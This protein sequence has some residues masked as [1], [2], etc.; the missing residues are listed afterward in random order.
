MWAITCYYNP[1]N[2]R[3]RYDNYRV[4]RESLKRQKVPL[5]TVELIFDCDVKQTDND[6]KK[7]VLRQNED[8][9][10]LVQ[11]RTDSVMWHKERL[12]NIALSHVPEE[13]EN[14]CW[15]DCDI[16]FHRDDWCEKTVEKLK[17]CDVVHP[18]EFVQYCDA[19]NKPI[20]TI[21]SFFDGNVKQQARA[22]WGLCCAIRVER[23]RQIGGFYEA[24]II[25]GGDN[26]FGYSLGFGVPNP[27]YYSIKHYE[28]L[29]RYLTKSYNVLRN[30]P[31]RISYVEGTVSHLWHGSARDRKYVERYKI[32]KT[33]EYDPEKVFVILNEKQNQNEKHQKKPLRFNDTY[34]DEYNK[35]LNEYFASRCEDNES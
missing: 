24:N 14:V 15:M 13:C 17:V 7:F 22:M 32:L 26:V 6:D 29:K 25:G 5:I 12:L 35:I 16:V 9:E 34:R 27:E 3:R 30:N 4:F 23:L 8:A 18:Y 1:Q 31:V 2:Y 21:K 19:N 10:V 11:L 33:L 20:K 28:H